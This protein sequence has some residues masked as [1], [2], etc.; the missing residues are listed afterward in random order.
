MVTVDEADCVSQGGQ[1]FRPSYLK[2]AEFMERL[3]YRPI[4]SAFTATATKEV[5]DDI[6]LI[7]RQNNPFIITT[8]FD[9]KNLHFA[10]ER[11]KKKDDALMKLL[12][13]YKGRNCNYD[14]RRID[15]QV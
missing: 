10:V 11:P 4:L 6:S 1:D 3:E 13:G 9:R 5:R 8:G 15:C 14:Q 2:I 12:A 7:L